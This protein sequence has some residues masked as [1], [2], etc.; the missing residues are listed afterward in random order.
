MAE[1]L[2]PRRRSPAEGLL[3]GSRLRELSF[4]A[5]AELRVDP[6]E[7]EAASRMAEQFLGCPLP[8]PGR[9]TGSGTPYV[10]WSGPGRYLVVDAD[11][12]GRGLCAGLR[13][14]LGGEYGRLCAAV[15]D[16]SAQ[17]TVLE[18]RG[19]DAGEV[20]ARGCPMDLHP[21]VFGPGSYAQTVVGKAAVGLHRTGGPAGPGAPVGPGA[22]G[23]AS[24]FRVLVR[25]SFADYLARFLTGAADDVR[26]ERAGAVG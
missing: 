7:A 4:L 17:R 24:A 11:A 8:G 25:A 22:E 18:L 15:A 5:Q 23:E 1:P 6:D 2:V 21:R 14:A 16:L 9:A 19:P 13:S 10:L 12:T 26:R 20:L 3:E